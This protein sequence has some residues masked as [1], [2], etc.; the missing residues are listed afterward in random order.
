M[1]SLTAVSPPTSRTAWQYMKIATLVAGLV[2][3]TVLS[4]H[5]LLIFLVSIIAVGL[6]AFPLLTVVLGSTLIMAA[7]TFYRIHEAHSAFVALG[8]GLA[9]SSSDT[10]FWRVTQ[11]ARRRANENS[12]G[13]LQ[14]MSPRKGPTP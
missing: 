7:L 5:G 13:F 8:P 4:F 3:D 2:L 10:G 14:Q 6:F 9:L 1:S 12:T 11:I